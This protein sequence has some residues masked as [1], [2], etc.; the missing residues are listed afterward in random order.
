MSDQ[1]YKPEEVARLL[2]VTLQAVDSWIK[3]GTLKAV[4]VGRITRIPRD[5]LERFIQ[6]MRGGEGES[7]P[8]DNIETTTDRPVRRIYHATK[9]GT[10]YLGDSLD[11]LAD[12]EPQS[13]DLII[14]SPPFGLVRQKDYG[15]VVADEYLEWFRP[16]ATAF[17]RI[18]KENGS[19]VIDIGG[20][21]IPDQPT[22]SIYHFELLVML[23]KEFGFHLAQEFYW[24]NPAKI[25]SPA[26]WVNIR[27]V[28]VKDA[29]N[30]VWWLSPSPW[31]KASNRRVLQPYGDRHKDLMATDVYNRGPRP[32]GWDVGDKFGTDNGGSIPPNLIALP[33]TESNSSYL[34]YCKEQGIEPHP[35]RYPAAL[36]EY[37]VRMLT[38]RGDRVVD[39]FAGSC[40]TG[41]VCER[42]GRR[43][44]C[45]ELSEVYLR[46]ALGRFESKPG[47]A[48]VKQ[49][50][51]DPTTPPPIVVP[52]FENDESNY[53]KLP[54]PGYVWTDV[55]PP[56]VGDGGKTRR[57]PMP[58]REQTNQVVAMEEGAPDLPWIEFVPEGQ[59][60]EQRTFSLTDLDIE[61]D[62]ALV[63]VEE[64]ATEMEEDGVKRG[65][66]V[67]AEIEIHVEQED[68][69]FSGLD[70]RGP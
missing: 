22:R 56:L 9:L 26:E 46:G 12:E 37:F 39:P 10:I 62:E 5:A 2:K 27:R 51:L 29:V 6:P 69:D 15:N 63:A 47:V 7:V 14:T 16:F 65:W 58:S 3:E 57:T 25:P 33:N 54:R 48:V 38:D 32:S 34:R 55:E 45:A 68:S 67:M 30:C 43:W 23:C 40:V 13:I 49:P 60:S 20:S 21:W 31:P 24:W 44:V 53:Y 66:E 19:L 52:G 11:V 36:P 4:K 59:A 64:L 70:D 8:G 1:Y 61:P 42:L 17:K 35:A 50:T 28:R 18:L 41:E